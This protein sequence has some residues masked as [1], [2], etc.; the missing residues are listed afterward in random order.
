MRTDS[1]TPWQGNNAYPAGDAPFDVTRVGG[2]QPFFHNL[3]DERRSMFRATPE[4]QY[5]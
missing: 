2:P 3:M 4:A 5:P 1:F